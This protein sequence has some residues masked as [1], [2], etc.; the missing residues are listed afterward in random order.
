MKRCKRLGFIMLSSLFLF[1]MILTTSC[2][3]NDSSPFPFF[4]SGSSD[5]GSGD[6]VEEAG[7]GNTAVSDLVRTTKNGDV[8]GTT[9]VEE[10][11]AWLGIPYAKPPVGAL[12]WRAPQA[13]ASWTGTR[14][15]S[16]FC[17]KCPQYGNFISE[18]GRDS[19]AGLW[20]KGVL[21]GSEDCLYLNV[22]RPK[23]KD[24]LPVF[25]FI[26]GGANVIGRS[27]LTIYNGARLASR[28]KMVVVTINYRLGTLGW[29]AQKALNT[30]DRKDDSGNF[31]TLDIIKALEW[32]RDNI[33]AFGGDPG[34]VTISGQSAGGMNVASMLVSPLSEGLFHRAI[35][36]S[37]PPQSV[38]MSLARTRADSILHRLM[39]RD[40][41]ADTTSKARE[42][43]AAKGSAW[44]ASYLRSKTLEELFPPDLGGPLGILMDGGLLAVIQMGL[45]EDGY[46]VP[47]NIMASFM[48]GNYKKVPIIL[49]NTTEEMKLFIPFFIVEPGVLFDVMDR[50]DPDNP[51]VELGDLLDPIMW[52]L[53]FA[54]DPLAK[55]GQ[56]VFQGYGVDYTARQFAAHQKNVWAYKFAWDEE[57]DP[58]DF[59][60]GA[61]HALDLPF[62]FGTFIEDKASLTSFAWSEANR[63]GREKLSAAMMSYYAQ[64]A[65]T[66]NPNGTGDGLPEWTPWSNVKG[67]PKR[68]IFDS[69]DPFMS[70]A[71]IEP[72]EVLNIQA[73]I[74]EVL[75]LM[76]GK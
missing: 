18:T 2:E 22:W 60:I 53:L 49:G 27:D 1:S 32:I 58:F 41:L 33:E 39:K 21:V 8:K 40:G 26:H 6:G 73:V 56:L 67:E 35:I 15:A 76:A 61:G 3:I 36:I 57:P 70:S 71:Y 74:Q 14:D 10:T 20:G 16:R 7:D 28:Q 46:V 45:Y 31:G 52:P 68:I 64:F 59:F 69:A 44:V 12:R 11:W 48:S 5:S 4:S 66:G 24:R 62:L 55:I 29:F 63:A 25:V 72:S 13:P 30:G 47:K 23:T 75:G 50:F 38:P 37:G 65:R 34:N 17:R 9:D 43:A 19:L 42:L 54:Y 51:D